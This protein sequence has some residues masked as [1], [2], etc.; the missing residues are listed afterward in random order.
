L[1]RPRCAHDAF[2]DLLRDGEPEAGPALGLGIRAV[3]LMKLPEDA[4]LM[5]F[6]NARACVRH[7]DGEVTIHA[8][9]VHAHFSG[10]RELDGIA[11][12]I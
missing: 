8:G 11:H 12:Q 5:L 3:N 1:I 10:I 2:D 4:G 7:T 9:G 6:G